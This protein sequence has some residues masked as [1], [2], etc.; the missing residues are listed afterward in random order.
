MSEDPWHVERLD[1]D[2]YLALVGVDR[3]SPSLEGMG[4]LH[5]A[6]VRTFAFENIDVLLDAHPGVTLEVVQ[7]KFLAGG[8]GGYCFEHATLFAAVLQRLGYDVRRQLG[9]VGDHRVPH[10]VGR[11]G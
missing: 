9:R 6:H 7:R 1:L 3:A 10:P 11:H 5:E 8:R 2:A 4:D